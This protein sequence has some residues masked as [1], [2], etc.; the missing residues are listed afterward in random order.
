MRKYGRKDRNQD[1]I[2]DALRRVGAKVTSTASMGDGFPDLVV[3]FRGA[4]TLFEV[5]MPGEDLTDDE[6][7]WWDDAEYRGLLRKNHI[8]YSVDDALRK[9]GA[10]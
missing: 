5:K 4:I 9:I 10:A 8:V 1:A 7:D 2:V 3:V 6:M